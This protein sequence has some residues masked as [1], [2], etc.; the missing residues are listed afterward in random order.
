MIGHVCPGGCGRHVTPGRFACRSCWY[1]L[2]AAIRTAIW[3][4]YRAAPLGG[5]HRAAMADARDFYQ[6]EAQ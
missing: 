4:G 6:Q 1:R 5:A 3:A 2:P